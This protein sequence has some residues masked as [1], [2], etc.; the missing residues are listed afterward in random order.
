MHPSFKH[1]FKIY[2]MISNLLNTLINPR[3][4]EEDSSRREYI[5]NILLLNCIILTF[6]ACIIS[7]VKIND[8]YTNPL[9]LTIS[10]A[11]FL[12]FNGLFI[13]S[14]KGFYR[15]SSYIFLTILFGLNIYISYLWGTQAQVVLLFYILIIVMSGILINTKIAFLATILASLSIIIFTYLQ[16]LNIYHPDL[17]WVNKQAEVEDVVMFISFF[18]IVAFVSWLSNREIEKSLKRA[19]KSEAELK[20]ERDTL[21]VRVEERTRDVQK[22]QIEKMTQVY[23]FAELGRLASGLFHDLINPLTAISLDIEKIKET[24]EKNKELI[25]IESSINR[26]KQANDRIQKL[27]LSI[28]K[29]MSQQETQELFSL[30]KEIEEAIQILAFKARKL[31]IDIQFKGDEKIKTLGDPIKFNQVITNLISNSIDSYQEETDKKQRKILVALSEN[32]N[33]IEVII[34]DNGS[35]IT[36]EIKDKIFDPFFTTKNHKKG[37]GIGLFLV[38]EIINKYLK[39]N[40]SVESK[41]NEGSTMTIKFPKIQ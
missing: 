29:Q 2:K 8:Y 37:T 24:S 18:T 14:K 30:S 38:K 36:E 1:Y 32:N 34:S 41:I 12:F 4:K 10:I 17:S 15:I 9:I 3:S 27:I 40:I 33:I 26:A 13:L 5:L 6:F 31:N 16:T 11:T 35:G 19:R 25:V 21:E 7:I 22:L 28:R 20:V 23:H 39:G